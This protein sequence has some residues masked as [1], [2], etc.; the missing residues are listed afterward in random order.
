VTDRA[1]LLTALTVSLALLLGA[2]AVVALVILKD[3]RSA[4]RASPP[5]ATSPAPADAPNDRYRR[6]GDVLLPNPDLSPGE[7]RTDDAVAVCSEKAQDYRETSEAL[8][9]EVYEEYGVTPHQGVCADTT[10]MTKGGHGKPPH[11]VV[12]SCEVDHIVS[13]ELGGKDTKK[14][15]FVQPYNPPN[16][17]P[18][19]HAKDRLENW[20]HGQVCHHGLPL[21]EAQRMLRDDWYQSYIDAGLDKK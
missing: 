16:G 13:L 9:K 10:R 2:L 6:H 18:G 15:L 19:A 11:E 21:P 14:N 17:V 4:K 12:E 7:A 3:R 1:K 20:L 8:K 5:P